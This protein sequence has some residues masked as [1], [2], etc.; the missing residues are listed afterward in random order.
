MPD[1][2]TA[3][4]RRGPIGETWWSKRFIAVLEGMGHGPRM[5][6]GRG[7]ARSGNVLELS[8]RPGEVA[9]SVAGTQPTPYSVLLN[10]DVYLP[11][12]WTRVERTLAGSAEY[13]AA[14]LDGRMP[15]RIEEVF[16][17]CGLNFFPVRREFRT[18][19]S[20]PDSQRPCK[21]VAAACYILA[22]RFDEDPFTMTAWRGR[23]RA[24]LLRRIEAL[25]DDEAWQEAEDRPQ[26]P[27]LAELVDHYWVSAAPLPAPLSAAPPHT[28][29]DGAAAPVGAI[30]DRLGPI[31]IEVD[32]RD[33]RD[34]LRPA[35]QSLAGRS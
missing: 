21:H 14:L 31:G 18:E 30:L 25:R 27:A 7:Y 20:C 15:E 10:I 3:R 4:S 29:P 13:A 11:E 33:V 1:G 32:G 34:L 28:A 6:R 35:Y 24:T 9:A 19:C 22:E 2:I 26:D 5:S 23:D 16:H 12:Q 8:I 17:A